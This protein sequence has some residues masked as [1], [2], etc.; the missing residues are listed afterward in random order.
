MARQ[1]ANEV[2]T[3][4]LVKKAAAIDLNARADSSSSDDSSDSSDDDD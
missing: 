1:Q 3:G 2:G 4:E